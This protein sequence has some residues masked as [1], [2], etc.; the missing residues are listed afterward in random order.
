MKKNPIKTNEDNNT[1]KIKSKIF[2]KIKKT[3]KNVLY[4]FTI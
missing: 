4:S 2:N 1:K 3:K